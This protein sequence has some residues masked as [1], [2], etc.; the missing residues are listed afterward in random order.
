M[1]LTVAVCV[2]CRW[3]SRDEGEYRSVSS[4]DTDPIGYTCISAGF[5]VNIYF[6]FIVAWRRGVMCS[7]VPG[8]PMC[9]G[10]ETNL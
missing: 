10:N 4:R 6:S 5:G 2:N 9:D 3:G 1:V 8:D 7:D